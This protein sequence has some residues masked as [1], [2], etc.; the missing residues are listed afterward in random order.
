MNGTTV[1]YYDC[2]T[3]PFPLQASSANGSPV[4]AT[5]TVMATNQTN[6]SVTLQGI[7]I[8]FPVGSDP[9]DFTQDSSRIGPVPPP[10]W[11]PPDVTTGD[12]SVQFVFHPQTGQGSLAANSNL[13]FTFNGIE[14]NQAPGT[15]SLTVTEGSNNCQPPDCPSVVFELAKFPPAWGNVNF[16]LNPAEFPFGENTTLNWSGPQGATYTIEYYTP[17]TGIVNVPAAGDPALGN[18]G[19]Y[20]SALDPPLSL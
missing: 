12:N 6:A 11:N 10:G 9:T 15:F 5:L 17:Q 2:S 7:I 3:S 14:V 16:W 13:V 19:L 4:T 8:E 18:T 20:P 1:L